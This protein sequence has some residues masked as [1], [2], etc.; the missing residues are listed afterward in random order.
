MASTL[1]KVAIP[2]A[3]VIGGAVAGRV[4]DEAL[5]IKKTFQIGDSSYTLYP[6]M[7][8]AAGVAVATIAGVKVPD[9]LLLAALGMAAAD[10]YT[11]YG[12]KAAQAILGPPTGASAPA[13][14]PVQGLPAP[15]QLPAAF[16]PYGYGYS[17]PYSDAALQASMNQLG[18][19]G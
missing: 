9:P 8:L 11:Q 19:V 7:A 14:A 4:L 18:A 1:A 5:D 6:S 13:Q 3:A 16:A 17:N 2:A 12:D 15:G 10:V